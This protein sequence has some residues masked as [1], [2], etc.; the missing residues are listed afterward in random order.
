MYGRDGKLQQI[1][2][3]GKEQLSPAEYEHLK[4]LIFELQ[5]HGINPRINS[6]LGLMISHLNWQLPEEVSPEWA[7]ALIECDRRYLGSEIR[8]MYYDLG[9]N[10]PRRGK[11][12]MLRELYYMGQPEIVEIVDSFIGEEGEETPAEPPPTS[13]KKYSGIE[14]GRE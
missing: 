4:N 7:E 10:A 8:Q 6:E 9:Y 13:P 1:L 5:S 12:D 14:F 3:A 11:K 2:K